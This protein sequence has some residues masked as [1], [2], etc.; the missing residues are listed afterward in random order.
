MSMRCTF[1]EVSYLELFYTCVN[2]LVAL[3]ANFDERER[4]L[5]PIDAG[6][7]NDWNK[8]KANHVSGS[9][10]LMIFTCLRG[11]QTKTVTD[12]EN[13][14]LKDPLRNFRMN[15]PKKGGPHP[16][17]AFCQWFAI[18]LVYCTEAI[19]GPAF[20]KGHFWNDS[21]RNFL[22][23]LKGQCQSHGMFSND[24][25]SVAV[26]SGSPDWAKGLPVLV[27]QLAHHLTTEATIDPT[28]SGGSSR[29]KTDAD[30]FHFPTATMDERKKQIYE[31]RTLYF[32]LSNI[33]F[34]VQS[35]KSQGASTLGAEDD[36]LDE[37]EQMEDPDA[38]ARD[39]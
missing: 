20:N 19:M 8:M 17:N 25:L 10:I 30:T 32:E 28:A 12:Q 9:L 36:L 21:P 24:F 15:N 34:E 31:R 5:P 39:S 4:I 35:F 27:H 23:R 33:V 11:P 26:R 14:A 1:S 6:L 3:K 16:G 2:M 22:A 13:N 7:P 38:R 29:R 37:L 18:P